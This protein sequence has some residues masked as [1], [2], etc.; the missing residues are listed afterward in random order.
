MT[1][2]AVIAGGGTSGH[3][4]PALAVAESLVDAGHSL[5]EL[6]Y[7]GARRGVETRLV[8]P[9]GLRAEFFDVVGLK[10]E[11]SVSALV[12]NLLFAPKLLRAWWR[13]V[14]HLRR[15]RPRVVVSVGGYASLPAV[16]G[17]RVLKIPIVVVTYDR[18]PGRSSALTSRFAAAVASAFPEGILPR[19]EYTGAPVR[20]ALRNLDREAERASARR[21]L[22]LEIDRFCIGVVGGSLGSGIL[23]DVT[24]TMVRQW[25]TDEG[26]AIRHVVGGRFLDAHRRM[27]TEAG[28]SFDDETTTRR[29]GSGLQYQIVGYEDDMTS[30]YAAVDVIVGRGGAGTVAEVAVTGTPAVLIPWVGSA[31][32]HQRANVAWLVD[33]GGALAMDETVVARELPHLLDELRRD[34]NRLHLLGHRARQAG[35]RSRHGAIADL[36]EHVATKGPT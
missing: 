21:R 7:F 14:R 26:M 10:R 3:V 1:T 11:I 16:L 34:P 22:G 24:L 30:M 4:L 5:A 17:A 23:N 36:V 19:S 33:Q 2:F 31:D 9:S 27:L 25:A 20:R 6:E 12:N 13:A 15:S 35:D 8:P 28:I 32:D 29:E 18:T